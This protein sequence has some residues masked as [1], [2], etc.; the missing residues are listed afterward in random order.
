[1]RRSSAAALAFLLLACG[2]KAFEAAVAVDASTAPSDLDSG[3][4]D[5]AAD[6]LE[7]E[8]PRPEAGD[9]F[10][11]PS[12]PGYVM[13]TGS[14]CD[15]GRC[16]YGNAAGIE[17][18]PFTT[19]CVGTEV[20][21]DEPADCIGGVCCLGPDP[22]NS[23]FPSMVCASSCPSGSVVVCKTNADC[24]GGQCVPVTCGPMT[25]GSCGG[26]IPTPCP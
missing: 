19:N 5:G 11:P 15:A 7:A 1:M 26:V 18:I 17:C 12:T 2:G 23:L 13:C 9:V 21:C 20:D 22:S 25:L 4:R 6:A 14:P 10:A 24:G 3:I 16:C 8:P